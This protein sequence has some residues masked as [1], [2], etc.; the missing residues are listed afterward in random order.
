MVDAGMGRDGLS[1]RELVGPWSSSE[2]DHC[3]R[4]ERWRWSNEDQRCS[5]MLRSFVA[6][7]SRMLGRAWRGDSNSRGMTMARLAVSG[8]HDNDNKCKCVPA[9]VT[10]DVVCFIDEILRPR[11]GPVVE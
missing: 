3:H 6:N 8:N 11:E 1:V 5:E 4:R 2:I 9:E 7:V 10:A